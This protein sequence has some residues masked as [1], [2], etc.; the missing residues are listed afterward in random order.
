ML[1]AKTLG[2]VGRRAA[3][4]RQDCTRSLY[5]RPLHITPSL[6]TYH[7]RMS[8]TVASWLMIL[9]L[10]Y[11]QNFVYHNTYASLF[12]VDWKWRTWKL[13]TKFAGYK[14]A[15]PDNTE[16]SSSY[17]SRSCFKVTINCCCAFVC[18]FHTL[19]ALC[20]CVK[21]AKLYRIVQRRRKTTYAV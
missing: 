16:H 12:W 20:S 18:E 10:F 13:R 14:I 19:Y 5:L 3:L 11:I 7:Y 4:W 9:T 8:A 6:R 21:R 17:N 15:K 1:K 2:S